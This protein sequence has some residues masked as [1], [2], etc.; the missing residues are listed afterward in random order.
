MENTADKITYTNT[1]MAFGLFF[2]GRGQVSPVFQRCHKS[3]DVF[4][5]SMTGCDGLV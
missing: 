1:V 2:F 5:T 3:V 4:H